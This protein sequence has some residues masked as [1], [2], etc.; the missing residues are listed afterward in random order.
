M[1]VLLGDE[2]MSV[3]ELNAVTSVRQYLGH[4][5]LEFQQSFLWHVMFPLKN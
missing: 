5:T 4:E 2:L 3:V 1:T